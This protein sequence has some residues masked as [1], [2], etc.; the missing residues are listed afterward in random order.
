MAPTPAEIVRHH[1]SPP[2]ADPFVPGQEPD[3]SR[4]QIVPY[5]ETWP[6]AYEWVASLVTR[7]LGD[8]V[9]LLQH[10]G[11][12]SVPAM[13]AKPIIDLDLTVVDPADES[14]YVPALEAVGFV[15]RVREPWWHEHRLLRLSEP[16]A[17][18]HVFGP[19]CP[20]VVRHRM[21]RDWL[22]THPEDRDRYSAAKHA[23]ADATNAGG[24]DGMDY[25]RH[26]ETVVREIYD[27][28]F[29]AHGLLDA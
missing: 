25:N 16:R 24:G 9:L 6:A 2:D 13:P 20:E 5:D 19:D 7:A 11:S 3:H 17:H 26:K 14:A 15:H 29:R 1:D 8:Q 18:L 23:A 28:L 12:T 4:L 21:F 10:I 27:H 22:R